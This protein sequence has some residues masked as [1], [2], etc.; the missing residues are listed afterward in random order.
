MISAY[1]ISLI[2][3]VVIGFSISTFILFSTYRKTKYISHLLPGI[4][5]CLLLINGILRFVASFFQEEIVLYET[6]GGITLGLVGILWSIMNICLILGIFLLFFSFFYVKMNSFHPLLNIIS[7]LMGATIFAFSYPTFTDLNYDLETV[8]WQATYNTLVM[9]LI[10]P[11]FVVFVISIIVPVI[12]KIRRSSYREQKSQMTVQIV[13]LSLVLIWSILA[14]FTR[15]DIIALIRPFLLPVGFLIW[16]ITLIA[17]PFNIMVSNAKI[18]Q[19]Y[20]ATQDGL[21][22]YFKDLEGTQIISSTLA[23]TIISGVKTA[24]EELVQKEDKLSVLTYENQVLGI[25]S[26]GPITAYIFGE[27]FDKILE[28][29]IMF[30]LQAIVRNPSLMYYITQNVVS[31]DEEFTK[32]INFLVDET[33]K[34]VLII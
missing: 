11:L 13:G 2:S 5:F 21:P 23:A 32:E 18:N 6:A 26:F 28:T 29:V 17:D 15:Y 7:L 33:L 19:I 27:R 31:L 1:S 34:S 10:L 20:I 30:L 12:T 25:V 4:S 22:F 8:S 16:S 24:L 14:A 3:L 9:I